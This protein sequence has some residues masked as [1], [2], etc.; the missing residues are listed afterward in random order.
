MALSHALRFG[1]VSAS[2]DSACRRARWSPPP[3]A[4]VVDKQRRSKSRRF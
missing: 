1:E 3:P 4:V 2:L